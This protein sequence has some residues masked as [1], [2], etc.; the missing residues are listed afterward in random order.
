MT[1]KIQFTYTSPAHIADQDGVDFSDIFYALW[2]GKWLIVFTTVLAILAGGYHAFVLETPIYKSSAV[3]ILEP[4]P[5]QISAIQ[6]VSE[7]LTGEAPEVQSEVE[8]LRARGLIHQVVDKLGLV[9]DPEFNRSLTPPT[10]LVR[11]KARLKSQL[12][13]SSKPLEL[14]NSDFDQRAK[15]TIVTELLRKIHVEN[16]RQSMVFRVTARSKE[17]AKAARI[18]DTVVDL[19]IQNQITQKIDEATQATK[20]LTTRVE[21]LQLELEVAENRTSEFSAST[22]LI[23]PE[24]LQSLKRQIKNLRERILEAEQSRNME[25][26]TAENLQEDTDQARKL[27]LVDGKLL[28]RFDEDG[29]QK[30]KFGATIKTGV[31]PQRADYIR[32]NQQLKTLRASEAELEAQITE[33]SKDLI[34]LQQLDREAHATRVLYE[35]FL[36]RLKEIAAQQGIQK[37]DSSVLSRA[38]IP[39]RPSDPNKSLILSISAILGLVS[40]LIVILWAEFRRTT[41]RS[42][43]ALERHCR[44]PVLSQL[45]PSPVRE[46]ME[47]LDHLKEMPDNTFSNAIRELRTSLLLGP[48]AGLPKVIAVT[49]TVSDEG[50][51]P[52]ALALARDLAHLN[53]NVLLIDADLTGSGFHPY[54]GDEPTRGIASVL[55]GEHEIDQCVHRP[56]TMKAD[57]LFANDRSADVA[58]L[59]LSEYFRNFV[60]DVKERY[61]LIVINAPAVCLAPSTRIVLNSSDAILFNV[62]WDSTTKSQLNS[63]LRLLAHAKLNVLGMVLCD[64]QK[65][66]KSTFQKLNTRVDRT[67]PK[68]LQTIEEEILLPVFSSTRRSTA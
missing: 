7:T 66:A 20:W 61:D 55:R 18:A 53:N 65:I 17:P 41:F 1:E 50:N 25:K 32:L 57:I 59:F 27:A 68:P 24:N 48:S 11:L 43:D 40:S 64:S 63:A 30:A 13:W 36:S 54:F 29:S 16:L 3:V 14:S 47:F 58:D 62:K 6:S 46:K 10:K 28:A 26:P 23:S 31:K 45:P 4:K 21:E 34:S 22:A 9:D 39:Y 5:D 19:Y 42:V 49:S 60:N 56:D 38:V 8:I 2:R 44:I 67:T 52:T 12:G 37:S 51:A 35:H 33:Q 15:D